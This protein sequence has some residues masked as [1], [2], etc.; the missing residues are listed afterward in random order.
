M[1][2]WPSCM[3]LV[4]TSWHQLTKNHI[5][6]LLNFIKAFFMHALSLSYRSKA[7]YGHNTV[8]VPYSRKFFNLAVKYFGKFFE[9]CQTLKCIPGMTLFIQIAK[10]NVPV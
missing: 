7:T 5:I 3:V 4:P 1:S 2:I 9:G 10:F 6:K 8:I